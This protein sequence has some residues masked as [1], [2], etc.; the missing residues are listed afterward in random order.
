MSGDGI[1]SLAQTDDYKEGPKAFI[2]KRAPK[3][4]GKRGNAKLA[5][6]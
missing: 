3:W 2:E 6:L 1:M 5:K 4:T